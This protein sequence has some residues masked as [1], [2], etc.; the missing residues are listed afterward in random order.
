MHDILKLGGLLAGVLLLAACTPSTSIQ[1]PLTARPLERKALP[2]DNGSIFQAGGDRP[3]F[4]DRRPRNVGDVLIINI[5]ET[6]AASEKSSSNLNNSGSIN[7][8]SPTVTGGP[9]P[10]AVGEPI[11]QFGISGGSSMTKAAKS[12]NAGNNSFSGTITVTVVEVLP[13]GNLMVSGEK[14]V[15]IKN[16]Q[17]FVR[18]SGVVNPNT[19][20]ASNTVQSTQVADVRVEYKG[21]TNIDMSSVTSMFGNFFLSIFPF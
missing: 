6:T 4:E 16:A 21:A 8:A 5:A 1:Q 9:A 14:Q 12:D 2:N 10:H 11:G 17:K 15:A 19:I 18:F 20:S 7:V 13:N 3:L